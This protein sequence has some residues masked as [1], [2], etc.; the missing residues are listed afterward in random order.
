MLHMHMDQQLFIQSI[1]EINFTDEQHPARSVSRSFSMPVFFFLLLFFSTI[2]V[3]PVS[4]AS[5]LFR[6]TVPSLRHQ[7]H[8]YPHRNNRHDNRFLS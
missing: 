6:P 8:R 5:C 4:A 2:L 1:K 7:S 3:L